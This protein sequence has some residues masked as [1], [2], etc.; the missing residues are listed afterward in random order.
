MKLAAFLLALACCTLIF[1]KPARLLGRADAAPHPRRLL[2]ADLTEDEIIDFSFDLLAKR[3]IT[4]TAPLLADVIPYHEHMR[5]GRGSVSSAVWLG[6]DVIAVGGSGGLWF[7][8]G[9]LQ[10]IALGGDFLDARLFAWDTSA[11]RLATA[12]GQGRL[13]VWGFD[14]TWGA[15]R[16]W[17]LAFDQP[18]S[19]MGWDA[20]QGRLTLGFED[21]TISL[22]AADGTA[23]PAP[24]AHAAP[25]TAL[26][27]DIRGQYL[28]SGDA[29]GILQLWAADPALAESFMAQQGVIYALAWQP[30][31]SGT[32]LLAIGGMDRV[33]RLWDSDAQT[34]AAELV[35]HSE[36]IH[37]LAWHPDGVRLASAGGHNFN[38]AQVRLWDTRTRRALSVFEG[39]AAMTQVAWSPS[40]DR[41]LASGEDH[42]VRL[43]DENG[44]ALGVLQ[45]HMGIAEDVAW[46]PDGTELVSG[47]DDGL[48]HL[49]YAATGEPLAALQ[50]HDSGVTA[51]AWSPRG[52][53]IASG[54]WDN[55]VRIWVHDTGKT[56]AV[57]RGHRERVWSV[58]WHPDGRLLASASRD[59]TVRVWNAYT[60]ELLMT[61]TGPDGDITQVRWSPDGSQLAAS[62]DDGTVWVWDAASGAALHTLRG[63][64]HYVFALAWHPDPARHL[65]ISGSWY[66]GTLRLWDTQNGRRTDSFNS[67]WVYALAWNP[68]GNLLATGDWSG[69]LRIWEGGTGKVLRVIDDHSD[70]I[71]ALAWSPDGRRLASASADGTLRLW[72]E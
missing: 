69:V 22:Y 44:A 27:W 59:L 70:T 53:L 5:L 52:D 7:Y 10:E 61:L 13:E 64:M 50:G 3:L 33:I 21:G 18:I 16:M 43:W 49:W 26:A 11:R 54:G 30:A 19:A 42:L 47:G 46:S 60:G 35:G 4:P 17:S 14:E 66:D 8:D 39:A 20:A 37:A 51:V 41:L 72:G 65:L 15:R 45:D 2:I 36:R 28:A 25:I 55:T 12:A 32:P 31:A 29:S 71:Y 9:A 67:L 62:S 23:L 58:T 34:F 57:L 63:H 6:E 48:V 24:P 68:T 40:G 1:A 56:R 38:G